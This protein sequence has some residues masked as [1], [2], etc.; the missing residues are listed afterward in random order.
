MQSRGKALVRSFL[1]LNPITRI[2]YIQR[3]IWESASQQ[4]YCRVVPLG[5]HVQIQC[6]AAHEESQ[7]N[8][9]GAHAGNITW[10]S[11]EITWNAEYLP[12]ARG[13]Q[14]KSSK[15][16]AIK[17]R[18]YKN[19][20]GHRGNYSVQQDCFMSSFSTSQITTLLRKTSRK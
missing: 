11:M 14:R 1:Y 13:V 5:P 16:Q 19:T 6:W 10:A 7:R 4:L 18:S 15:Y 8:P 9:S 2:C 12:T 3:I 20:T 17:P